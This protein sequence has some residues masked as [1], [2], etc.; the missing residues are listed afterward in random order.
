LR[1]QQS[2][3]V[4]TLINGN[5][6]IW[7][8]G[9]TSAAIAYGTYLADRW[10]CLNNGT[11]QNSTYS[12]S[13]SVPNGGSL[14]SLKLQQ[15]STSATSVTE[16]NFAQPIE[17]TMV[18]PLAGKNVVLSF[19]YRSNKTGN[20]NARIYA[21]SQTGGTDVTNTFTVSVADTW[22]YKTIT[23]T[24]FAAIT[25]IAT[26]ATAEGA[27]VQVGYRTYAGS[28]SVT[29]AANDYFQVTQIKLEVGSV[30]TAFSRAGGTI[31]GELAACQR[32]YF[33]NTGALI[34]FGSGGI[35]GSATQCYVQIKHPTTMRV[36]PTTLDFSL[37]LLQI[38]S[39]STNVTNAQISA[40]QPDLTLILATTASG[41]TATTQSY[42]IMSQNNAAAYLGLSAEL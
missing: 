37:L 7:Q 14:Y 21:T 15:L 19:W 11:G 9:T 27:G 17:T 12:Q 40:A 36:A 32:Y 26:G 29:V 5:A 39:G 8:R 6:D 34:Y 20:H 1:Y 4:N 3:G 25:A 18:E 38:I 2:F 33:R 23:F 10:K 35:A 41:L 28:G 22:E 24:S 42:M 31:Q 30:A 16:Y 13:T